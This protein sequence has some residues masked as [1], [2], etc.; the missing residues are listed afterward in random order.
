M[1]QL[2]EVLAVESS[3]ESKAKKLVSETLKNLGKEALY[4]GQVRTLSHFSEENT[5]L[6]TREV[7][8]MTAT[9][10]ENI[11]YTTAAVADL[12]DAVLQKEATNQVA[13]ADIVVDGKTIAEKVPATFLLGL[14][15]KLVELRKVYEAI[16]TLPVGMK[17]VQDPQQAEGIFMTINEEVNFKEV[18]EPK[19][20]VAYEATDHHP[21]QVVE[22]QETSKVGKYVTTRQSSL[23]TPI[24]KAGALEKI[25]LL[26][27]AVKK[28]RQRAN[29]AEVVKTQIGSKLF[30]FINS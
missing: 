5:Q 25:D 9:V 18:K 21:A 29:K 20:I 28:A 4:S 12:W 16:H 26:L 2:H 30:D 7:L 13:F 11:K 1:S 15:K 14:E 19:F 23:W 8:E 10:D 6:D 17:W 27:I 24:K 3:L 22:K